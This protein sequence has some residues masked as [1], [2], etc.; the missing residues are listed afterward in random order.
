V[1]AVEVAEVAAAAAVAA[2]VTV[3]GEAGA[4]VG[5]HLLPDVG[6][7]LLPDVMHDVWATQAFAKTEHCQSSKRLSVTTLVNAQH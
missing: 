4:Q 2:A 3:V 1:A 6:L 5:P 7:H